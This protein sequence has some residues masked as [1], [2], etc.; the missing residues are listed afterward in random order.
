[1]SSDIFVKTSSFLK[2]TGVMFTQGGDG[3]V[4]MRAPIISSHRREID[5]LDNGDIHISCSGEYRCNLLDYLKSNKLKS[6]VI[7]ARFSKKVVV[8]LRNDS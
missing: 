6:R 5:F 7:D 3:V 4:L 8:R 1:M 2:K